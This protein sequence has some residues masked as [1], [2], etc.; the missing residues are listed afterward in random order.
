MSFEDFKKTFPG[1]FKG[2]NPV[3]KEKAY[4]RE[5]EKATG[6][7]HDGEIKGTSK[8]VKAVGK[9]LVEDKKPGA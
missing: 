9:E 7:K 3:A 2:Y 4:V 1:L 5:F 6:Q 8:K